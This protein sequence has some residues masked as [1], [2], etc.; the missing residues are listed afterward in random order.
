MNNNDETYTGNHYLY[1]TSLAVNGHTVNVETWS[2]CF[3]PYR[4]IVIDSDG[5][6]VA[7]TGGCKSPSRALDRAAALARTLARANG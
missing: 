3:R 7:E 6:H 1:R 2:G 5:R 4:G